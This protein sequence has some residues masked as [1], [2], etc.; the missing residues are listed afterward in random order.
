MLYR[1]TGPL[2]A[3]T[4]PDGRDVVLAPGCAVDL[5]EDNPVVATF[6]ALGRLAAE[7]AP[8]KIKDQ[9]NKE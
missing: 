9:S 8:K 7:P 1:Y 2:T 3:M 6:A 4:L 5:P